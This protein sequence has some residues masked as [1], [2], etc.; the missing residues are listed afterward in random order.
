MWTV[1]L[2][3]T[4]YKRLLARRSAK[5]VLVLEMSALLLDAKTFMV[6][7]CHLDAIARSSDTGTS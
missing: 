3:P 7:Q 1:A 2:Q 6:N 4:S 5:V